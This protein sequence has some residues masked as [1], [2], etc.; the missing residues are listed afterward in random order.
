MRGSPARV[1]SVLVLL[2]DLDLKRIISPVR[3]HQR[4]SHDLFVAVRAESDQDIPVSG[5]TPEGF[6]RHCN[7]GRVCPMMGT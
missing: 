2:A 4:I 1:G 3:R 5:I 7:L 6:A